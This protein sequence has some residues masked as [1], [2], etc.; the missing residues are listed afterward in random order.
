MTGRRHEDQH[1]VMHL[2]EG[3]LPEMAQILEHNRRNTRIDVTDVLQGRRVKEC[4][5][6]MLV[7]EADGSETVHIVGDA[8]AGHLEL[9][10]MLHDAIYAFAHKGEPGFTLKSESPVT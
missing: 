2:L 3:R 9:K 4:V 5:A 8:G 10:G 7:E 1:D 6:V